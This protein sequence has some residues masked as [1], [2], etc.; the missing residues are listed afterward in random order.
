MVQKV[1]TLVAWAQANG[2]G[3]V[4]IALFLLTAAYL[5]ALK[6]PGDQPDKFIKSVLDFTERHSKKKAAIVESKSAEAKPENTA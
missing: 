3:I 4:E 1:L 6:I 5:I 2:I